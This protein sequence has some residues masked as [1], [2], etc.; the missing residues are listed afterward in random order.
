MKIKKNELNNIHFLLVGLT[1]K[2]TVSRARTKLDKQI[3]DALN[4]VGKEEKEL[5]ED[6]D[7]S[8]DE[9]GTI[10]FSKTEEGAQNA[11]NF[12][13]EHTE[14]L[15]EK[16]IFNETIEGHYDRLKSVLNE[17]EGEFSGNDAQAYD[18]LLDSLE[19]AEKAE[20]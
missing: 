8:V 17:Y 14:L 9:N 13:K 20:G 18:T 5:A 11:I 6:N 4:E 15:A 1:L 2:G 19:E 3:I 10:V 16:V 7:G 12:K